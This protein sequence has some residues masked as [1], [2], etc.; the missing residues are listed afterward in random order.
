MGCYSPAHLSQDVQDEVTKIAERT[1]SGMNQEGIP[2]KGFLFLGIMI[3]D[4]KPHV[5][6]FN[7]RLGDPEAQS[8]LPRCGSDLFP[9]LKAC[10]DGDLSKMAS[11]DWTLRHSVCVVM[12]SGGYPN[13]F[14]TG[15]KISGLTD[16]PE[17]QDVHV[18]HAGTKKED[19]NIV[20]NGGRVLGVT[21]LGSTVRDAR[22]VAYA[23]VSKISWDG[24]YHRKDIASSASKAR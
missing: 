10:V 4:G 13:K 21:A 5:L 2:Y 12:A 14:D 15:K 6:E 8:L 9:Y 19:D 20:T 7:V 17:T 22:D 3:V 11:M 16:I 23:S 18:F 24:E 1:V